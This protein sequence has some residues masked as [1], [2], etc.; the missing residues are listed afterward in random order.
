MVGVG[1][2]VP[3]ILLV[4]AGYA[5]NPSVAVAYLTIAQ[6]FYG[7]VSKFSGLRQIVWDC[8]VLVCAMS[9]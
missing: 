8:A 4:L 9:V 2:C 3:A 7:S 1:L 5:H 6:F